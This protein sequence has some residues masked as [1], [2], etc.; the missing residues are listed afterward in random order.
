MSGTQ[1]DLR[2]SP[3]PGTI[4]ETPDS[5]SAPVRGRGAA[6]NPAGRFEVLAYEAVDDADWLAD[7]AEGA[8]K[9]SRAASASHSLPTV[10]LRDKSREIL[11]TNESPDVPFDVGLNPYRGCEHGCIYCYARP[12]HEFLGFSAGLDFEARILVKERAPEL[13]REALSKRNW[14]PQLVGMSGVTDA[15]QPIERRLRLTRRCLEVFAETRNP[16]AIVTKSALVARDIDILSSLAKHD[17]TAVKIS[18]TTLDPELQRRM[19][20]RASHPE[21]RLAAIE[22]LAQARIP[23][24]IMVA[25][26]IPGLTDHELPRIL[27]AAAARGAT[28]ASIII[29]RLPHGVADLFSEWLERHYPDRKQK[30]LNR[31]RSL[32]RGN[33]NDPRFEHRM[34][35]EGHYATQINQ[36]FQL[37]LRKSHLTNTP[38]THTT[39][40]FRRP[41]DR[42]LTLNL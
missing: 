20:P 12:T 14:R 32:R 39:K 28:H 19:E 15:Y 22:K 21:Q 41:K 13:L 17:A 1:M 38:P 6:L 25:P 7:S 40:N 9:G 2:G 34:K 10:Y 24:G 4:P 11:S 3:P 30:V 27:E 37:A 8:A 33:L 23:V 36:L 42:Q 5:T 26:V 31:L 35:G 18:L 16:V 29:L